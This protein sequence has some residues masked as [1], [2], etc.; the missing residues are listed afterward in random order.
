MEGGEIYRNWIWRQRAIFLKMEN[1][2]TWRKQI[3]VYYS[4]GSLSLVL[5]SFYFRYFMVN[6]EPFCL[7]KYFVF[8]VLFK[9]VTNIL[10]LM[11]EVLWVSLFCWSMMMNPF[12]NHIFFQEEI[13]YLLRLKLR[14]PLYIGL[15]LF[16]KSRI[17]LDQ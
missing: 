9:V 14:V 16:K 13:M 7:S 12:F 8:V 3:C 2:L 1:E 5:S 4:F 6:D 17:F 15:I 11:T 10:A